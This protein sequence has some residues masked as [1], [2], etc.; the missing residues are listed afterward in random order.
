MRVCIPTADELGLEARVHG[1]FGSA[2]FFTL[3]DVGGDNLKI[4]ANHNDHGSHGACTPL[5]RLAEE[6]YD[7]FIVAGMGRRAVGAIQAAGRRVLLA[8]G[9]T[10]QENLDALEAGKLQEMDPGSACQGHH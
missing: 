6:D 1:H 4:I 8:Q 10:V 9:G 5:G 2:P 3:V 7:V